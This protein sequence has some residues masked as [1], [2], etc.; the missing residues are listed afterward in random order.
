M[1]NTFA[2][3]PTPE[4]GVSKSV[5][6]GGVAAGVPT[7]QPSRGGRVLNTLQWLADLPCTSSKRPPAAADEMQH[8]VCRDAGKI[9]KTRLATLENV[10]VSRELLIFAA[11]VQFS[12]IRQILTAEGDLQGIDNLD[13]IRVIQR[14]S[15]MGAQRPQVAAG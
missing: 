3:K 8:Q 7:G 5:F 11:K 15:R 2:V 14:H 13:V 1:Q 12:T 10:G 4:L 9:D 6:D